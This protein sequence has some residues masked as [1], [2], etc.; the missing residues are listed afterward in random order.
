MLNPETN[1]YWFLEIFW[2]LQKT[3][4]V[5]FEKYLQILQIPNKLMIASITAFFQKNILVKDPE[6]Q[7]TFYT[8]FKH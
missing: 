8:P 7:P 3:I 4:S 6:V 5:Y 2:I 1:K